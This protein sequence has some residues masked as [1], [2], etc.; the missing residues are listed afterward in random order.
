MV[1]PIGELANIS[2]FNSSS[3]TIPPQNTIL[4]TVDQ[5]NNTEMNILKERAPDNYDE[6]RGRILS[7]KSN[8]SRDI[9]MSS[10]ISSKPYHDRMTQNNDM[11]INNN[12]NKDTSPELFYK[13]SQEKVI[14]LS[15]AAEK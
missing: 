4:P 6:V 1:A 12:N 2:F 14:R 11:D 10:M 8:I 5:V 15:M 7:H 13:T 3:N 9:S